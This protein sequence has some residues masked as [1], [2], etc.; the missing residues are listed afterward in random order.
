MSSFGTPCF[1]MR[2]HLLVLLKMPSSWLLSFAAFDTFWYL[3]VK[4]WLWCARYDTEFISEFV[5]FLEYVNWHLS[6]ILSSFHPYFLHI[7]VSHPPTPH[8]LSPVFQRLPLCITW[9]TWSW[10][11]WSCK[12][13]DLWGSMGVCDSS[14]SKESTCS[15][16]DTS[17]IPGSGKS[18][19]E[20]ISYPL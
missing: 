18:T 9:Y 15:E 3:L 1:L 10:Y 8:V 14:V 17:L 16:G 7:H 20:G 19:G 11:T 2:N 12:Y 6:S 13:R 4:V 5:E